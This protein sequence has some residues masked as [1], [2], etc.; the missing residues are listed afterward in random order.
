MFNHVSWGKAQVG[1]CA[2]FPTR[3]ERKRITLADSTV[4]A[5]MWHPVTVSHKRVFTNKDLSL[6]F[7]KKAEISVTYET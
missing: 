4:S 1:S 5:G 3:A 7:L 6:Y 2:L